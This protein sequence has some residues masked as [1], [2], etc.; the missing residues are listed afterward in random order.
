MTIM[1]FIHPRQGQKDWDD[2]EQCAKLYEVVADLLEQRR[3]ECPRDA[4]RVGFGEWR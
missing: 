3:R 2:K 4:F 1:P